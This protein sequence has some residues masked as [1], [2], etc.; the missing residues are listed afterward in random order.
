MFGDVDRLALQPSRKSGSSFAVFLLVVVVENMAQLHGQPVLGLVEVIGPV[1]LHAVDGGRV[2]QTGTPYIAIDVAD[3]L[4]IVRGAHRMKAAGERLDLVAIANL[5]LD[6]KGKLNRNNDGVFRD[7]IGQGALRRLL[8]DMANGML[9]GVQLTNQAGLS[10]EI[11]PRHDYIPPH[12]ETPLRKSC[13]SKNFTSIDFAPP[14]A[15]QNA[16]KRGL[17]LKHTYGGKGLRAA[18]VAKA[19]QFAKGGDNDPAHARKMRAWFARHDTDKKSGWDKP[20]T[21]GFVARLLWGGD[22]G[23]RWVTKL[24]R[25]V[26]RA[27]EVAKAAKKTPKKTAT[28]KPSKRSPRG[29]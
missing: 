12:R 1:N 2:L 5:H 8:A 16:C 15:V 24:V 27:E 21:P 19:E 10:L 22:A 7:G 4:V 11:S 17:R 6:A 23:Q 13:V 14:K 9:A 3:L 29:G 26:E 28:K 20:P 18:T 25:E